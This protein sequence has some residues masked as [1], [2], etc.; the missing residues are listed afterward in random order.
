MKYT[1]DL[2]W[3]QSANVQRTHVYLKFILEKNV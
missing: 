1:Y 2:M 3:I